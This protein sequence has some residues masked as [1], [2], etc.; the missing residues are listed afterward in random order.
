M[1]PTTFRDPVRLEAHRG[2]G[3]KGQP[4]MIEPTDRATNPES[5]ASSTRNRTP[6]LVDEGHAIFESWALLEYLDEKYPNPPLMPKDPA[7]RAH[8]RAMALLGY[9]YIFQ[10]NRQAVMQIF[11]WDRWDSKTMPYPPRRPADQVDKSIVGPAEERL[12]GHYKVLN[13]E[14]GKNPWATGAMFGNADHRPHDRGRR[15]PSARG[16]ITEFLNVVKWLDACLARPSVK[17][18][19]TPLVKAGKAG[20]APWR[21]PRGA[22]DS[23]TVIS[24]AGIR[25]PPRSRLRFA[26]P[27]LAR[28]L[29]FAVP[30]A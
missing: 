11:E 9:L 1:S 28:P 22:R 18:H 2:R 19:A 25:G 5:S 29:L 26:S 13:E 30:N 3:K 6:T 20:S 24:I 17:D 27:H 16:P 7:G 12:M 21:A 23:F 4:E 8:A 14:L 15:L 10:D